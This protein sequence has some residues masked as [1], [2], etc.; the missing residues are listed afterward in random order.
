MSAL[1]AG[2]TLLQPVIAVISSA[3]DETG[4]TSTVGELV[5]GLHAINA[6]VIVALLGMVHR[7]SR[8]LTSV[9]HVS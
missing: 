1:V 4:S 9:A 5:F 6:L 7:Q 8:Q 2:L 3:F